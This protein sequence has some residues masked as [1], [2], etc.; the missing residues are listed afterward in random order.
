MGKSVVVVVIVVYLLQGKIFA[1]I[2]SKLPYTTVTGVG[3]VWF[4][5]WCLTP[6]STIFQLYRGGQLYWWRKPEKNRL[7]TD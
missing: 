7:F 5:L 3:F 2:P 6:L 1:N 4:S